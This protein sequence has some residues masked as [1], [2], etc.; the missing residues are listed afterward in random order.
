MV[1]DGQMTEG[2]ISCLIPFYTFPNQGQLDKYDSGQ[3]FSFLILN[4]DINVNLISLSHFFDLTMNL[5]PYPSTAL[6]KRDLCQHALLYDLFIPKEDRVETCHMCIWPR[7]PDNSHSASQYMDLNQR[8]I[9]AF[10]MY[11]L[12]DEHFKVVVEKVV[13]KNAP[14]P[15]TKLHQEDSDI[16]YLTL[17]SNDVVEGNRIGSSIRLTSSSSMTVVGRSVRGALLHYIAFACDLVPARGSEGAWSLMMPQFETF[18]SLQLHSRT[19][20]AFQHLGLSKSK[21]IPYLVTL[22]KGES[23][24]EIRTLSEILKHE[25]A[26]ELCFS[27]WSVPNHF[28][29]TKFNFS[30][31]GGWMGKVEGIV[32]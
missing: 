20:F 16:Q 4:C 2:L 7:N 15:S 9:S 5:L 23:K 28:L 12:Y 19:A 10:K 6:D 22:Q 14:K 18:S 8:I 13:L 27:V 31:R 26:L 29:I 21:A 3:S 17:T 25:R 11:G 24:K 30:G 32:G 1:H